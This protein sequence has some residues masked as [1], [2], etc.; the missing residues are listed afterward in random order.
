VNEIEKKTM[1]GPVYEVDH[2][3]KFEKGFSCTH[4]PPSPTPGPVRGEYKSHYKHP[5]TLPARG[6]RS[7]S[8]G[9]EVET[10]EDFQE[11]ETRSGDLKTMVGPI[12]S[13]GNLVDQRKHNFTEGYSAPVTRERRQEQVKLV[14][15]YFLKEKQTTDHLRQKIVDKAEILKRQYE[16]R[17]KSESRADGR[18]SRE[19]ALKIGEARRQEALQRRQ[20]FLQSESEAVHVV[21]RSKKEKMEFQ[22]QTAA[23]EEDYAGSDGILHQTETGMSRYLEAPPPPPPSQPQSE[24]EKIVKSRQQLQLERD[25][26][27]KHTVER[28]QRESAELALRMKEEEENRR[29]VIMQEQTRI[30]QEV[31]SRQKQARRLEE[32]RQKKI[33]EEKLRQ[34][35]KLRLREEERKAEL[36]LQKIEEEKRAELVRTEQRRQEEEMFQ[37]QRRKKEEEERTRAA[38]QREIEEKRKVKQQKDLAAL[39]GVSASPQIARRSDD[40]HGRG[41]GQ[42]KTGHVMTTKISFYHRA[43]STE[44]DLPETPGQRRRIVRFEGVDSSGSL[45]PVSSRPHI[46]TGDV[47][48]N[49]RGWS[50][51]V[52]EHESKMVRQSPVPFTNKSVGGRREDTASPS[53]PLPPPP[54]METLQSLGLSASTYFTDD[55]N[56]EGTDL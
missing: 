10:K 4:R 29:K 15:K 55:N 47:A 9:F 8:V 6:K 25:E 17:A 37:Q 43:A 31:K 12:Y 3:H 34:A 46:K 41:F 40:V 19:E 21:Q 24:C 27:V 11:K 2:K 45:S 5:V 7:K 51:K 54:S 23:R 44:R 14:E 35:E 48:V 53:P 22:Q 39:R 36:Q 18:I 56:F 13:S 16:P 49:I 26:M 20:H 38:R 50:Q 30:D 42:V 33:E 32:E 28:F 1:K 52:K